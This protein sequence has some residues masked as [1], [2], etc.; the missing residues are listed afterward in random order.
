MRLHARKWNTWDKEY[1][2]LVLTE[3]DI[4][5][6]SAEHWGAGLDM[7]ILPSKYR[8][9]STKYLDMVRFEVTVRNG[10]IVYV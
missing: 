3:E 6:E 5:K 7:V 8:D 10:E 9:I 4:E 2:L 1:H